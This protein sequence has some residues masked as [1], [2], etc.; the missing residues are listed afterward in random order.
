VTKKKVIEIEQIWWDSV[1]Q[2]FSEVRAIDQSGLEMV[3]TMSRQTDFWNDARSIIYIRRIAAPLMLIEGSK[4]EGPF[5]DPK[6][7][8]H[9]QLYSWGWG[10]KGM[11]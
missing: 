3:V 4:W 11:P 8:P 1:G 9:A 6:T 5:T 7:C 2:G 10:R